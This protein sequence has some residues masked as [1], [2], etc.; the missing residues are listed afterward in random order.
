MIVDSS[1]AE[2]HAPSI[3]EKSCLRAVKKENVAYSKET[4]IKSVCELMQQTSFFN[5]TESFPSTHHK[6][7][8]SVSSHE[9]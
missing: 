6:P 1:A 4:K 8:E 9:K 3:S 7:L 2:C 5:S